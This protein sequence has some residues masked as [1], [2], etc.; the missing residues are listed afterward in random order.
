MVAT[1]S[2]AAATRPESEKGHGYAVTGYVK[3]CG[4]APVLKDGCMIM[5]ARRVVCSAW[6]VWAARR[7]MWKLRS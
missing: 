2:A 1:R 4:Q 6:T 3:D 5:G 7:C